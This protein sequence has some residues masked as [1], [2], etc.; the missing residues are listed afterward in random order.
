MKTRPH[1][2]VNIKKTSKF[3]DLPESVFVEAKTPTSVHQLV[4]RRMNSQGRNDDGGKK[5][6][7]K[8]KALH[9]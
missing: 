2:Y 8:L 1:S 9:R 6:R 5:K 3:S 4:N 7:H